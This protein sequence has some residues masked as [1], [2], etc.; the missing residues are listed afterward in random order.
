MSKYITISSDEIIDANY[1][2]KD[3]TC[4]ECG[5]D[6]SNGNNK[7]QFT[8]GK[9]LCKGCGADFLGEEKQRILHML[10]MEEQNEH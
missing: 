5:E 1:S 9:T 7:L 3:T 4:E 8:H 10:R 6:A 2:N